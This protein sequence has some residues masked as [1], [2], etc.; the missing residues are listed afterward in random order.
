MNSDLNIGT[1]CVQ[2]GWQ[3]GNGEPRALPIWQSTTWKYS[4]SEEMGKLFD[5]EATGYIRMESECGSDGERESF[6]LEP[7][8]YDKQFLLSPVAAKLCKALVPT[9]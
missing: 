5:L 7:G 2:A 1:L 3:P 8:R 9:W 6:P 4:T